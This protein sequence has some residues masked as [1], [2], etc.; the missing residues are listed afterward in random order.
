MIALHDT[1]NFYGVVAMNRSAKALQLSDQDRERLESWL[2]AHN[3]PQAL[4]WRKIALHVSA[5]R[6]PICLSFFTI[7]NCFNFFFGKEIADI[8][9]S[10]AQTEKSPP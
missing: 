10:D 9:L 1:S 6:L 8:H 4:T 2:R 5:I 3:T 7:S